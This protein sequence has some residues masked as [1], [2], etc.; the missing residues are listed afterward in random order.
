LCRCTLTI[1]E[2]EAIE[3]P[4]VAIK[5]D[6]NMLILKGNA[7]AKLLDLDTH[8]YIQALDCYSRAAELEG[9][10]IRERIGLYAKCAHISGLNKD[11]KNQQAFVLLIDKLESMWDTKRISPAL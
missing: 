11:I 7:S 2:E 8:F 5:E 1:E 3:L 6:K 9:T 4:F 10:S